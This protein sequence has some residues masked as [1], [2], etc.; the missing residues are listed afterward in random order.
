MKSVCCLFAFASFCAASTVNVG[1]KGD[2]QAALNTAK[3]GDTITL[4]SGVTYKG[5]F[6]LPYKSGT[7]VI[8]IVSSQLKTPIIG[9]VS[10]AL[11]PKMAKIVSN[12]GPALATAPGAH[13][14]TISAV[15]IT[16]P[17][18]TY[19]NDLVAIGSATESVASD[20]P[21]FITLDHVYIHGDPIV[22]T[23]RGV[24]LNGKNLTVVDSHISDIKSSSQDSQAL[25]GWNGPGPIAI[26]NNYLEAAGENVMFGG[27]PPSIAGTI[28]S[29]ILVAGNH[30]RKP[31]NWYGTSWVVK[32]LFELKNAQ[33]VRII[34]NVFENNWDGQ[35]QNGTGI[36]FTVRAE[37]SSAPWAV[38]QDVTFELNVLR[39]VTGGFVLLGRDDN[40]MGATR[41]VRIKNNLAYNVGTGVLMTVLEAVSDLTVD[42]N[43][44]DHKSTMI[45]AAGIPSSNFTWTNNIGLHNEYG[46]FGD[47]LGVGLTALN[48]Y[49]TPYTFIKNILAG[50]NSAIYPVNNWYPALFSSIGFGT[51]GAITD[52]RLP[53]ASEYRNA[54][55]DGKDIGSD[56]D[57]ILRF[58]TAA[59]GGTATT[60]MIP[61]P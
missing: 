40:G 10:P 39:N 37:N 5:N 27:A 26:V 45:V 38:I 34:G 14:Y 22:G 3:P 51:S 7:G 23:K 13:H 29:D 61:A 1:A 41:R 30:L 15:E 57:A 55:T 48:Y 8:K 32:N 4:T 19:I 25:C 42:H 9:R 17:A 50:A 2:F 21:S 35:G 20:L 6:I 28:P 31:P 12:G 46:I 52:Y 18:D 54:G 24:A 43:T 36:V 47:A 11:A 44:F 16:S 33:R 59:L 56:N 58:A 60:S 53:A 49:L